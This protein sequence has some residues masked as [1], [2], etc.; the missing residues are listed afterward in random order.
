MSSVSTAQVPFGIGPP[1]VLAIQVTSPVGGMDLTTATGVTL[2]VRRPDG[3]SVGPWA[4][5]IQ[6]GATATA[7]VVLYVLVGNEFQP[8]DGTWRLAPLLAV[9]GGIVPCYHSTM[10]VTVSP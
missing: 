7:L 3:T 2:D 6:A 9:S 1:N 4:A 8:Y 10:Q 5:T